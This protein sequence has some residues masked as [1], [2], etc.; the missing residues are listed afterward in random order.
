MVIGH[1]ENSIHVIEDHILCDCGVTVAGLEGGER[2]VGE[3]VDALQTRAFSQEIIALPAHVAAVWEALTESDR[4]TVW[5]AIDH[6]GR[7]RFGRTD[8]GN[9][10]C[11]VLAIARRKYV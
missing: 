8:T 9:A 5:H 11:L 4:M 3:V 1:M 6:E 7:E 2:G 10:D